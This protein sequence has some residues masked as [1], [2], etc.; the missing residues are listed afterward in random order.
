MTLTVASVVIPSELDEPESVARANV[1]AASAV[2]SVVNALVT[3]ALTL[4]AASVCVALNVF[5]PLLARSASTIA[6]LQSPLLSTVAVLLATP[7]SKPDTVMVEATTP[8]P[9]RLNPAVFSVALIR[10]SVDTAAIVGA[11]SAVR[12]VVNALV[13]A[14]LTLPAASVCVALNVF[15]PLLARSA[16]TIAILQSPL[17][18]TVAVLLATP[19]SKPDTVMVEATTPVPVRLNPAVFSVALIRSSVDTAAIVGAASA[20]VSTL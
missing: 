16:S 13:T 19:L 17:L 14:A 11:A 8:V 20:V 9:V 15:E 6:I 4:P 5:E 18:S 3:A 7:L 10:S 2:R 12:S 1:G